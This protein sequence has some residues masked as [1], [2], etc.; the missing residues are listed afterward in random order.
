MHQYNGDT[1]LWLESG[2][3]SLGP[4]TIN[5]AMA[6]ERSE[7]R[8]I[9]D[10]FL[11][12]HDCHSRRLNFLWP[13]EGVATLVGKCGCVGGCTF[14]GNN[15]NGAKVFQPG[16]CDSQQGLNCVMYHQAESESGFG[17]GQSILHTGEFV[18]YTPSIPSSE[19]TLRACRHGDDI[20]DGDTARSSITLVEQ[21]STRS[22]LRFSE[23]PEGSSSSSRDDIVG[24]NTNEELTEDPV[25]SQ[26]V[27]RGIYRDKVK[28][29]GLPTEHP[30]SG[31]L[32][33]SWDT[34]S[35]FYGD[36]S[37][38]DTQST[39]TPRAPNV[40]VDEDEIL[41]S[42]SSPSRQGALS[43]GSPATVRRHDS[44]SSMRSLTMS[45]RSSLA[46]P[47]LQ[48]LSS[49]TS[50]QKGS[51]PSVTGSE[52]YFSCT[53][54]ADMLSNRG[55]DSIGA[56]SD[57]QGA[58]PGNQSGSFWFSHD[59]DPNTRT[60]IMTSP[61]TDGDSSDESVGS[62]V[63]AAS[64]SN[65]VRRKKGRKGAP[66]Y[67]DADTIRDQATVSES[68]LVSE[69]DDIT[70]LLSETPTQEST[71]VTDYV[72]L[73]N[74]ISQPIT[75]SPILISSYV[76]HMTQ[77]KCTHWSALAPVPHLA[78][79]TSNPTDKRFLS[80]A[81]TVVPPSGQNSALL[82]PQF[83]VVQPGFT[84]VT[85]TAK[86]ETSFFSRM[87]SDSTDSDKDVTTEAGGEMGNDCDLSEIGK[88]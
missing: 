27:D 59:D 10:V 51:S 35:V 88:C 9:Q 48:R 60:V 26:V 82:I 56:L 83:V 23:S 54:D 5:S 70:P 13:Q 24:I 84:S 36:H 29:S 28:S 20:P 43:H 85:M 62:F 57:Y 86:K 65:V 4:I 63:S 2:S 7:L 3:V 11:K 74:Q 52:K 69:P 67:V 61:D 25:S 21:E 64:S 40:V 49:E 38:P 19:D 31:G 68:H 6:L 18:F 46:S 16:V 33:E 42:C 34:G 45:Q 76:S 44:F 50:I 66:Q 1:D 78:S 75:R 8:H 80:S 17:F 30:L 41:S 39:S 73:H 79:N 15:R 71:N 22:L 14:F 55:N 81:S 32:R 58:S 12:C 87:P 37:I 53:E 47:I 77:L 72:N